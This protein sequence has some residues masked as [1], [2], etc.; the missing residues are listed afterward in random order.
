LYWL[1]WQ[2]SFAREAHRDDARYFKLKDSTSTFDFLV[3]EVLDKT[4]VFDPNARF[5]D[6][7]ELRDFVAVQRDRVLEHAHVIGPDVPQPCRYCGI[8]SYQRV[9]DPDNKASNSASGEEFGFARQKVG[10][11]LMITTCTHCGN[12]QLFRLDMMDDPE[13]WHKQR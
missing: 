9:V 6:A 10:A 2:T 5:K 11:K 7:A 8:G 1:A 13:R 4:I 12:L 3:Y